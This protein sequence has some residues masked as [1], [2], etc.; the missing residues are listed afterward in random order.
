MKNLPH[1]MTNTSLKLD[2]ERNTNANIAIEH[3]E[4][5]VNWTSILFYT[6]INLIVKRHSPQLIQNSKIY[7]FG[8]LGVDGTF[9]YKCLYCSE[10]F[11]STKDRATHKKIAHREIVTCRICDKSFCNANSLQKHTIGGCPKERKNATK[12]GE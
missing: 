12:C 3:T 10:Y 4:S 2:L 6:V 11:K 1:S 5:N 8:F 9:V 7:R